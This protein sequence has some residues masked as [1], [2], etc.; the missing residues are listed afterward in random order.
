MKLSIFGKNDELLGKAENLCHYEDFASVGASL[1]HG[2]VP[3]VMYSA[4]DAEFKGNPDRIPNMNI[5]IPAYPLCYLDDKSTNLKRNGLHFMQNLKDFVAPIKELIGSQSDSFTILSPI[6]INNKTLTKKSRG[7]V[8]VQDIMGG[9]YV[10]L[11]V[12]VDAQKRL[13]SWKIINSIKAG[14]N[15]KITLN[16]AE[17]QLDYVKDLIPH[18]QNIFNTPHILPCEYV[19]RCLQNDNVACGI[20]SIYNAV[21]EVTMIEPSVGRISAKDEAQLR[22][23][24]R[25]MLDDR[26]NC[27]KGGLLQFSVSYDRALVAAGQS[28]EAAGGSSSMS[29]FAAGQSS[30]AAAGSSSKVDSQKIVEIPEWVKDIILTQI[31]GIKCRDSLFLEF[32]KLVFK[33]EKVADADFYSRLLENKNEELELIKVYMPLLNHVDNLRHD[34]EKLQIYFGIKGINSSIKPVEVQVQ[35]WIGEYEKTM[36]DYLTRMFDTGCSL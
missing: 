5:V 31:G 11:R 7:D 25:K 30:E 22:I 33:M 14:G 28:S 13:T 29:F 4:L 32:G 27:E 26:F 12:D 19:E 17:R 24:Y 9:H 8:P 20:L 18:M 23:Q 2:F 10:T 16:Y 36:S 21:N 1:N 15:K 3:F 6:I 34:F 35:K